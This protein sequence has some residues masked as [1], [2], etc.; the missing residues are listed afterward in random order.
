MPVHL[1]LS[2]SR[3]DRKKLGNL[4]YRGIIHNLSRTRKS[5]SST[6]EITE[7][8]GIMLMLD[9]SVGFYYRVFNVQK[10]VEYFQNDLRE[11]SKKGYLYYSTI[12]LNDPE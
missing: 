4:I 5:K 11:N 3:A 7:H 12:T 6:N 2:V 8:K 10:S 1:F 9:L